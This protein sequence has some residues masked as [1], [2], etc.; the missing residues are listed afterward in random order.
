MMI[1][2]CGYFMAFSIPFREK[3]REM[4]HRHRHNELERKESPL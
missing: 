1:T 4:R 3:E 2:F